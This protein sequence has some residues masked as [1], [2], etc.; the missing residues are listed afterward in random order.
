MTIIYLNDNNVAEREVTESVDFKEGYV[1][2]NDKEVN[3]EDLI[4]IED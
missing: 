3:V 2:F 4:R 1:E